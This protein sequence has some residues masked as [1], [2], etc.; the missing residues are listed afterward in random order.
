MRLDRFPLNVWDHRCG[1][2]P[3]D[4]EW[5]HSARTHGVTVLDAAR[6]TVDKLPDD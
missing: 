5:E 4:P 6:R 3:D 1:S 2:T